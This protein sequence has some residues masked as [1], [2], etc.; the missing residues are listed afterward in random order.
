MM[1]SMMTAAVL[2][3][4]FDVGCGQT[5][6]TVRSNDTSA[7]AQRQEAQRE[8]AA[9]NRELQAANTPLP[10]PNLNANGGNNPQGYYYDVSVYNARDEHLTRAQELSEHARQH[11]AA[12][13]SL[14]KF[15]DAE[16]KQ[17]PPSSRSACPL[18]GPVTSITDIPTGVRVL[19]VAGTRADAVLAHMRC[20]LAFATARGF[21]EAAS[22]PLY[23]KGIEV[24]AGR[25]SNTIEIVST[26]AKVAETIRARSR[27][28]AVFIRAGLK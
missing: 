22:C 23:V 12:A 5:N 14:E 2:I 18:L 4:G 9:A 17:F 1:R 13:A 3:L 28:E 8:S 25:I 27:D 16:C 21:G 7:E 11:E 6:P 20:H 26:D 15:E 24:R 19:L 10:P